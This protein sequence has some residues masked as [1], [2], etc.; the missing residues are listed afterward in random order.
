[1]EKK[2]AVICSTQEELD[3]AH[4]LFNPGNTKLKWQDCLNS[5]PDQK[6][7][8]SH[9]GWCG[10]EWF[11]SNN[12]TLVQFDVWYKELFPERVINTYQIY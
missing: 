3:I 1:M 8:T 7:G 6:I 5:F 2:I 9:R 12:Y 11:K 10:E 4:K